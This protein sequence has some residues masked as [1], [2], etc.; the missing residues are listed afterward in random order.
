MTRIA[1]T[2]FLVAWLTGCASTEPSTIASDEAEIQAVYDSIAAGIEARDIERVTAH[3]AT[4]AR[5]EY[6]DGTQLALADWKE[7]ARAKWSNF[8]RAE[9]DFVVTS[10]Q[11]NEQGAIVTYVEMDDMVVVDPTTKQEH[12]VEYEGEWCAQLLH[13]ESGWKLHRSVEQGR[14]VKLDGKI[15]DETRRKT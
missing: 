7:S 8:K 13:T 5:V 6:A 14:R 2:V 12:H 3:S 10:V 15:A 4:D 9:S 11:R 1:L